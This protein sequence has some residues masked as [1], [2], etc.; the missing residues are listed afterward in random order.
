MTMIKY[1]KYFTFLDR[2][3]IEALE[4]KSGDRTTQ[5]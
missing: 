3:E 1:I 4:E 2:E 5:T